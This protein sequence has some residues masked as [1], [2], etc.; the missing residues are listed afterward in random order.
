MYMYVLHTHSHI[1]RSH[2]YLPFAILISFPLP[3]QQAE[4]TVVTHK[5]PVLSYVYFT[6][7]LHPNNQGISQ[8]SIIPY[9]Q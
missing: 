9:I 5:E 2:I 8:S 4:L 7:S 3:F 1:H 6:V